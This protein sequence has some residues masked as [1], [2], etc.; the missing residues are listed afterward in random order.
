[1]SI[2]YAVKV[3]QLDTMEGR[4]YNGDYFAD[5]DY[6]DGTI[7]TTGLALG[8]LVALKSDGE[9]GADG[10]EGCTTT[11]LEYADA[12]DKKPAAGFVWRISPMEQEKSVPDQINNPDNNYYPVG[13]STTE[14]ERE[15]SPLTLIQRGAVVVK[16]TDR[17]YYFNTVR[18]SIGTV[19]VS[20][21]GT[22]VDGSGTTFTDLRVGDFILVGGEKKEIESITSDTVLDVTVAFSGIVVSGEG[23]L[24]SDLRRPIYL[25]EDGKYT[26]VTPAS[27][28]FKQVV[29][30]VVNGNNILINLEIDITG[31]VVD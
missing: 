12:S 21:A 27:G 30:Y 20:G 16:D 25:G 13:Y 17:E 18:E 31:E 15:E 23:Y 5:N 10:Y 1:M 11:T 2:T 3:S 19:E 22:Q 26:K 29:G 7:G 14:I 9:T 24:E 28:D 4:S 8:R 6:G